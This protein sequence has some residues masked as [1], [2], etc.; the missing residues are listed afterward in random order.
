L[1]IVAVCPFSHSLISTLTLSSQVSTKRKEPETGY[2]TCNAK[3][4]PLTP[5]KGVDPNR[6]SEKKHLS[7]SEIFVS[8]IPAVR[9]LKSF[10]ALT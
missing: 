7:N 1:D 9:M 10:M 8:D 6:L 2:Y 3:K 4:H 5:P